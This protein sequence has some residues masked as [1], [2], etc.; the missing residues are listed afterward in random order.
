MVGRRKFEKSKGD[1]II[2]FYGKVLMPHKQSQSSGEIIVPFGALP[3]PHE[4]KVA[5]VLTGTG[6]NVEFI[7]T[8]IHTT[9]DIIFKN[10]VWEIKSPLGRNSRAIENNLRNALHQSCNVILDLHRTS[11]PESKCLD[12][13]KNHSKN[14]RGLK[15]LLI[16]TS[17]DTI[18]N[19]SPKSACLSKI[20][21]LK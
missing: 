17:Q 8:G 1:F 20:T 21:M 11:F 13:I 7:P 16:I 6:S 18:F 14:F 3:L 9:S 12:Y 5:K 15:R 4:L 10:L 19:F 2:I